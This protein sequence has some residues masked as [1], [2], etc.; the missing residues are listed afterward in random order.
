[1][2]D[3]EFW[4]LVGT[5]GGESNRNT[6]GTL[7]EILASKG[8]D[9]VEEFAEKLTENMRKLDNAGFSGALVRDVTDPQEAHPVPLIGDALVNFHFAVIAAGKSQ[10]HEFI[11]EPGR[12]TQHRWDFSESDAIGEAVTSAY[13]KITGRPWP[14]P[15]PG[16]LTA[17]QP[18]KTNGNIRAALPELWLNL[19]LHGEGEIPAP[20]FDAVSAVAES[21]NADPDWRT[22]WSNTELG[23]LTVEI[24]FGDRSDSASVSVRRGQA[25]ASFRLEASRFKGN[26]PGT[27]AYLACIDLEAAFAQVSVELNTGA[28]PTVPF[29]ANATPPTP[30]NQAARE[31]LAQLRR[32]RREQT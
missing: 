26:A 16:H 22:W 11:A 17:E 24:E 23:E 31:R 13:E 4:N 19:A 32:R 1:M 30:K 2:T 10:F 8:I 5:L 28:P 18:S 27:L 21:I 20:Y 29:P 12:V 25:W 6:V 3:E 15:L 14:G 7:A 9:S